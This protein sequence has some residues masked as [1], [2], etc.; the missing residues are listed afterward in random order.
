[1]AGRFRPA[2][3]GPATRSGIGPFVSSRRNI[4]AIC[5]LQAV[6]GLRIKSSMHD[7]FV[8]FGIGML[9]GVAIGASLGLAMENFEMGIVV[10][11]AIGASIAG[12]LLAASD[13]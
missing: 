3:P 6:V 1:M 13:E 12:I 7:A 10:G 4:C 5:A 11:V 8:Q 2:V 9:W